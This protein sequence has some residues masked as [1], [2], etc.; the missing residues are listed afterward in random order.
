MVLDNN[1]DD[2]DRLLCQLLL[3]GKEGLH[4]FS[5]IVR[6]I[7]NN[8]DGQVLQ[9]VNGITL[10]LSSWLC[11]KK[12]FRMTSHT[13]LMP[14]IKKD[15]SRTNHSLDWVAPPGSVAWLVMWCWPSR[16][17]LLTICYCPTVAHGSWSPQ[18]SKMSLFTLLKWTHELCVTWFNIPLL[19]SFYAFSKTC[20]KADTYMAIQP[21]LARFVSLSACIC[22]SQNT[23][24]Y[25]YKIQILKYPW[26]PALSPAAC[27]SP[28][29]SI[30]LR[31]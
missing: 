22:A 3:D 9:L 13:I 30:K 24:S 17:T 12:S 6:M 15:I 19:S 10:D 31:W 7:M 14:S 16:P 26:N 28:N 27:A 25:V 18:S 23:N 4:S 8:D 29:V 21:S 2:I 11:L 1:D 5:L 20:P